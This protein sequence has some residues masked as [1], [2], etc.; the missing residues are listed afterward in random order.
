M[1]DLPLQEVLRRKI[2]GTDEP[3]G[4]PGMPPPA[5]QVPVVEESTKE[6]A[7]REGY[8]EESDGRALPIAGLV[9]G[10]TEWD[11]PT[12]VHISFFSSFSFCDVWM[13]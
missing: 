4:A 10:L 11:V 7:Q 5:P 3:P 2:W 6:E 1:A 13:G 9:P 12:Y 8:I